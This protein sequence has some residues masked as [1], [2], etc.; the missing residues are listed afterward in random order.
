[1]EGIMKIR[2]AVLLMLSGIP[3]TATVYANE[4]Q[5]KEGNRLF[6]KGD[7]ASALQKYNDALIDT[8]ESSVLRFNAGDA[9][10][11]MG[12]AVTA[13]KQ[14]QEAGDRSPI[15]VLRSAARYNA[16]NALYRQGKWKEA[17]E[18]YKE[19]LRSNPN[20]QDAKYNLGVALNALKNPPKQKPRSGQGKSNPDKQNQKNQPSKPNSMSQQDAER[21]LSAAGAGEQKKQNKAKAGAG[22]P[23]E[24][25]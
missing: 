5:L 24:D 13:E 15:P 3:L 2:T 16:G 1:M 22:H 25:W 11:Q 20:D 8:P 10:Y 14:F 21:L 19:A 9:A 17:I 12:D 6:W 7:Y 23:D 4:V 18:A